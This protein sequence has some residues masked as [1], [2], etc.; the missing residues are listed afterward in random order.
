METPPHAANSQEMTSAVTSLCPVECVDDVR[1]EAQMILAVLDGHR[2]VF[3]ELV[4]PYESVLYHIALGTL[5][6][7]ADAEDVTQETLLRA[8]HKLPGFRSE[9]RFSTWL[10]TIAMNEA[11]GLLRRRKV[12]GVAAGESSC[13]EPAQSPE[14]LVR[15]QREGPHDQLARAELG[16]LLRAAISKLPPAYRAV[17]QLRILDE[18]SIRT[19]AQTLKWSEGAVK[20]RLYRARRMLRRQLQECVHRAGGAP[21][22]ASKAVRSCETTAAEIDRPPRL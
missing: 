21:P 7:Q 16:A 22:C 18:H 9:A 11:R 10:I 4:R 3:A 13:A 12:R 6:N 20:V 5:R 17:L 8:F 14:L 19:T 1:D 2:S 15:D